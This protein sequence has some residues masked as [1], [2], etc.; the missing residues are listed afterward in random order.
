MKK[1]PK[2]MLFSSFPADAGVSGLTKPEAPGLP[3]GENAEIVN[4]LEMPLADRMMR[5]R[6]MGKCPKC[7]A[8][9]IVCL[10]LRPDY[11][12]FRCRACEHIWEWSGGQ[13]A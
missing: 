9:P 7:D 5:Y 2:K 11:A 8:H 1:E 6:Q 3:S 13:N 12:S 10:M 4:I